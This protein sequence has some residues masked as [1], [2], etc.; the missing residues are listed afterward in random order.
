MIYPLSTPQLEY[1]ILSVLCKRDSYGY[2]ISQQLKTVTNTKDSTQMCIRD[3]PHKGKIAFQ[4]FNG[5]IFRHTVDFLIAHCQ[6]AEGVGAHGV[7]QL[8]R[9]F[10]IACGADGQHGI[11]G[12][13]GDDHIFPIDSAD[14]GHQLTVGIKGQLL[15]LI[16]ISPTLYHISHGL[17]ASKFYPCLVFFHDKK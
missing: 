8:L 7:N 15:S 11:K 13:L 9:L 14:N 10:H 4:F 12:A 1:L 3:R 17:T 2:E 6:D 16:H 5:R